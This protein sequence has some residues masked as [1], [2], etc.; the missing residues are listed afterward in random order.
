MTGL[1]PAHELAEKI[2]DKVPQLDRTG[3]EVAELSE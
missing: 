2:T 1:S 3:A